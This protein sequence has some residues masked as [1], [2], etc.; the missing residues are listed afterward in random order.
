MIQPD[1]TAT[2]E[3]KKELPP[4]DVAP[5]DDDDDAEEDGAVDT[6]A[7]GM[8]VLRPRAS[9]RDRVGLTRGAYGRRR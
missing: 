5:E 2:F 8:W 1:P 7:G 4:P 6:P 3:K 9:L